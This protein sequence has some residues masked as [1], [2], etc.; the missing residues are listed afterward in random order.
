M[1]YTNL[2][3]QGFHNKPRWIT[4]QSLADMVNTFT[5]KNFSLK[6]LDFI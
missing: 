1:P 4:L 5:C 2:Y 3:Y 6:P